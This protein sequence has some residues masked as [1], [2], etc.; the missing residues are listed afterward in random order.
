MRRRISPVSADRGDTAAVVA[1]ALCLPALDVVTPEILNRV[2]N[3]LQGSVDPAM[4]GRVQITLAEALNNVAEHACRNLR[5]GA[6]AVAV[7]RCAWGLEIRMTDWGRPLPDLSIPIAHAPDPGQ[8][9]EGGYGWFLIGQLASGVCYRRYAD[10]NRL[11]LRF[12]D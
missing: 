9:A 11:T 7:K 10:Q 1:L 2:D 12:E 5:L 4:R 6:V 8:L 3:A